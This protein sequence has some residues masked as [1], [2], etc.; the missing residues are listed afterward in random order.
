MFFP[1][2]RTWA[3][4]RATLRSKR[5]RSSS[6]AGVGISSRRMAGHST[7]GGLPAAPGSRCRAAPRLRGRLPLDADAVAQLVG[8]VRP[9]RK[10]LGQRPPQLANRLDEGGSSVA[11]AQPLH[12]EVADVRPVAVA[13]ARVNALIADD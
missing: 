2:E 10:T 11:P 3:A 9:A 5:S 13:D 4:M 1:V 7:T 12:H 6:R 8:I